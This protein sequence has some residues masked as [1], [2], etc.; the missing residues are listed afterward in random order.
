MAAA[1]FGGDDCLVVGPHVGGGQPDG[2]RGGVV[3]V[4]GD[5]GGDIADWVGGSVPMLLAVAEDTSR[6][7][8]ANKIIL[9]YGLMDAIIWAEV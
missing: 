1:G 2:F 8:R 4:V 5:D 9:L 3:F 7:R 6:R